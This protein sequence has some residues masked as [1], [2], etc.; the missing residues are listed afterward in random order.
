MSQV[1]MGIQ[2]SGGYFEHLLNWIVQSFF[3]TVQ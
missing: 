2:A 1:R 3:Q